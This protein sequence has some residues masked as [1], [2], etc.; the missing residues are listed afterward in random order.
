MRLAIG[1]WLSLARSSVL[2]S[3]SLR[4]SA[5]YALKS[6]NVSRTATK[7]GGIGVIQAAFMGVFLIGSLFAVVSSAIVMDCRAD[8]G[9]LRR[10]RRVGRWSF[11][12]SRHRKFV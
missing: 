7:K 5:A 8:G 2:E 9:F 6:A 12:S 3:S 1:F 4:D 10:R 11:Q